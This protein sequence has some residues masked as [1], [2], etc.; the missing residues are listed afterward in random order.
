MRRALPTVPSIE[1]AMCKLYSTSLHQPLADS[2]Y[3]SIDGLL[4][5]GRRRSARCG[6]WEWSYRATV[7]IRSVLGTIGNTKEYIAGAHSNYRSNTDIPLAARYQHMVQA[8]AVRPVNGMLCQCPARIRVGLFADQSAMSHIRSQQSPHLC[9]QNRTG[10]SRWQAFG[11]DSG[12][13]FPLVL[14]LGSA[15]IGTSAGERMAQQA[16]KSADRGC[17]IQNSHQLSRHSR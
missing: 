6:K 16:K 3:M 1:A 10:V 2:L 17:A 14:S 13:A 11:T 12:S 7:S 4:H 8:L 15:M 5:K 9:G